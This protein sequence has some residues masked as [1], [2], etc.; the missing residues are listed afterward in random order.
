MDK[1]VLVV[2][3]INIELFRS[4]GVTPEE[5]IAN[6][7]HEAGIIAS[8]TYINDTEAAVLCN[9]FLNKKEN[10]KQATQ[11]GNLLVKHRYITLQELKDALYEQKKNPTQKLGN[12]LINMGFCTKFDIE[13]CITSQNQIR[14]DLEAID[15]YRDKINSLRHRLSKQ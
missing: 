9:L 12:I 1:N 13:R 8:D 11:L 10:F 15:T 2:K 4:F 5:V 14:E 3:N 6:T 7:L